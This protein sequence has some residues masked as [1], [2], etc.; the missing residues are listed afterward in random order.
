MRAVRWSLPRGLALYAFVQP[1]KS[2]EFSFLPRLTS[3]AVLAGDV[4]AAFTAAG[5]S[6]F[7]TLVG[8]SLPILVLLK[9]LQHRAEDALPRII[10]RS[11]SHYG[12]FSPTRLNRGELVGLPESP[13]DDDSPIQQS[14]GSTRRVVEEPYVF[15]SDEEDRGSP[16]GFSPSG[17]TRAEEQAP[18]LQ[19]LWMGA[20]QNR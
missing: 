8:V 5:S 6:F 4:T 7:L 15:S 2:P 17:Q 20:K 1:S 10:L 3:F 9:C 18:L 13:Y 12:T 16:Q 11:D 14:G 19:R